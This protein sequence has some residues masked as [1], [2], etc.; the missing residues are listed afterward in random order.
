MPLVNANI[1]ALTSYAESP[2]LHNLRY[3]SHTNMYFVLNTAVETLSKTNSIIFISF[4]DLY[5]FC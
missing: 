1:R 4:F 3:I 2:K 5:T